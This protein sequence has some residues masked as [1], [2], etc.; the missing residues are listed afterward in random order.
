MSILPFTG[1]LGQLIGYKRNGRYFLRSMPVT[2]RQT[3]A[4]VRASRRFGL[5]SK[6]G[7]LLRH[8][9]YP[10]LD[11]H[12][13]SGHINRL[14]KALIAAGDNHALI[15]GYRFNRDTGIGH[16]LSK[17]PRLFKNEVLHIPAQAFT[18]HQHMTALEVKVIAR[19]LD[20]TTGH[21][22]G[23]ATATLI[24][25]TAT[26][27]QGKNIILDVPG[28]GTLVIVFQIRCLHGNSISGNRQCMAADIIAVSPPQAP[29]CFSP[30][31]FPAQA[32][33][34]PPRIA[35]PVFASSGKQPLQRE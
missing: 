1:K 14:N 18:R 27:F 7:A 23:S 30:H 15:A 2:V 8:A 5:A 12:C 34:Q 24:I 16:F 32:I 26:P 13:D 10:D 3:V 33:R 22:T 20:L 17:A 29:A 31:T 19:R 9:C 11:I 25:D 21:I 6:I 35:C 28:E 4:T